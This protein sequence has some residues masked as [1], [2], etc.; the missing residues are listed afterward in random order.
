MYVGSSVYIPGLDTVDVS[1]V[2]TIGPEGTASPLTEV[3]TRLVNWSAAVM[4]TVSA[5]DARGT[6]LRVKRDTHDV[7]LGGLTITVVTAAREIES[8]DETV[9]VTTSSVSVTVAVDPKPADDGERA[10]PDDPALTSERVSMMLSVI[11]VPG[12]ETVIVVSTT[13]VDEDVDEM[14]VGDG[15]GVVAV[16]HDARLVKPEAWELKVLVEE[17]WENEEAGDAGEGVA[18]PVPDDAV[19]LVA[20]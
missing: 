6:W 17:A 15:T 11:V 1:M 20:D 14:V 10:D 5:S 4:V 12:G 9:T 8:V 2:T 13:E 7:E 18:R 16:V 3:P 19:V